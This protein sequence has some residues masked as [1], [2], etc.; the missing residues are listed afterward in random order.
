MLSKN[1][2]TGFQKFIPPKLRF[3][4][5]NLIL[6]SLWETGESICISSGSED[7]FF[8]FSQSLN[9]MTEGGGVNSNFHISHD[10]STSLWNTYEKKVGKFTAK[11]KRI[12]PSDS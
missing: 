10:W 1:D 11:Q 8:L 7:F 6:P 5:C 9:P 2:I 12:D 4:I 3:K